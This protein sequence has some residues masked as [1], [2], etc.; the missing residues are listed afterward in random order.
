MH[1]TLMERIDLILHPVRFRILETLVGETL[2]TQEMAERLPR[3]PKS[4]IYRH[5]RTLLDGGMI[6]IDG[7]RPVRGV[8]EKAYRLDQSLRLEQADMSGLTAEEHARYFRIY[9]M[10]LIQG[11]TAYTQSAGNS[12]PD[13]LADRAGYTET[14]VFATT[15]ELD[16]FGAALNEALRPLLANRPAAERRRHKIAFITHPEHTG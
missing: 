9:A 1:E 16:R 12:P 2:T 10:T 11:F 3:V 4:S 14:F 8:V 15:E 6:A 5:L 13:M 7:T